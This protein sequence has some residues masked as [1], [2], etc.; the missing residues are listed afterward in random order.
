MRIAF[1]ISSLSNG[2]AEKVMSL[3]ANYFVKHNEVFLILLCKQEIVYD[4][5]DNINLIELNCCKKS[6]NIIDGIKNNIYRYKKLKNKITEIKPDIIISFLTQTNILSILVANSL[7][8]PII[9]SEHSVYNAEK[10]KIWKLLRRHLYKKSNYVVTL[11]LSDLKHYNFLQHVTNISNPLLI[12]HKNNNLIKDRENIVLAVGRLHKVKQFDILIKVFSQ[13][14]TDY[15]LVILGE[16]EER[17]KLEKIIKEKNL[18]KRVFLKGQVKNVN[19]YYQK[20]K[21]FVLCSKYESFSNVLLEAMGNGCACISFDCPYGP[22]EIITD[23]KDGILVKNQDQDALKQAIENLIKDE[24][25]QQKL[26]TN[27][28]KS[29][30]RFDYKNVM[31]K[32]EKLIDKLITQ[33]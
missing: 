20:S 19:D 2:G 28:I 4:I 22:R 15:K 12:N 8:I 9:S 10:S 27:A 24:S 5:D 17:K 25:Y 31:Q 13:I 6:V 1:V 21:I 18:E 30:Q 26:S 32:W 33:N 14:K 3:L 16:G 7:N 11:T 23:K 29:S